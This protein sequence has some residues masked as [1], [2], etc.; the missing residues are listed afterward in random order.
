VRRFV[1]QVADRAVRRA[2][3]FF[4][5]EFSLFK[6]LQRHFPAAVIRRFDPEFSS[7]DRRRRSTAPFASPESILSR[8]C[9]ANSAVI[10][11]V[12]FRIFD[13]GIDL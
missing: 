13:S 6:D 10:A 8:F 2:I 9:G 11:H 7:F 12:A 3:Q 4:G 5:R 1:G